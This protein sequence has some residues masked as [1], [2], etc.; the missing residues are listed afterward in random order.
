[1]KKSG[2]SLTRGQ[3]QGSMQF[4]VEEPEPKKS[5]NFSDYID[6]G[7]YTTQRLQ[8]SPNNKSNL[9]T[10]GDHDDM[11]SRDSLV[12]ENMS[13]RTS[14]DGP[15]TF[16]ISKRSTTVNSRQISFQE[17]Y[18]KKR[19]CSIMAYPL[20][21]FFLILLSIYSFVVIEKVQCSIKLSLEG[22]GN[23]KGF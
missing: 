22:D 20:T 16:P 3:G 1:M 12:H 7:Q 17:F 8:S 10:C 21:I 13:P 9:L 14:G 19:G 6:Y 18:R 5:Q 23:C 4:D 11:S 15:G 2:N